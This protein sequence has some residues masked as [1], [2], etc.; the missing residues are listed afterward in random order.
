M[1]TPLVI[2]CDPGVDDFI[3]ISMALE[4]P[5]LNVLALT[6]TGGNVPLRYASRNA[7]R[8]LDAAGR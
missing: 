2:D 3:A 5:E 1:K 8:A 7:L 4:S 6:T